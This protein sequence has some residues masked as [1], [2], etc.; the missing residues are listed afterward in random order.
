[1]QCT[2]ENIVRG[3]VGRV[4]VHIL[5]STVHEDE[6]RWY[7]EEGLELELVCYLV[8]WMDS[9]WEVIRLYTELLF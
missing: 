3:W 7:A 6:E 5:L 9:W 2:Q 4:I 8:G 1:M